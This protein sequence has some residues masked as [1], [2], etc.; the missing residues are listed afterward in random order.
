MEISK[1]VLGII[2]IFFSAIRTINGNTGLAGLNVD[3]VPE[4][5]F[6]EPIENI[7]VP[8]GRE[9]I[10][11]CSVQNLG[12]YKVGW[13]RVSDQTVLALQGRVVTHNA[14]YSV[15]HEDMRTWKLKIRQ[16]RESDRGCYMCQINASPMKKQLGCIDVYVPPDINDEESS[17]DVTARE[18]EDA[19]LFCSAN[20]H[21]TP[22]ITWRREDGAPLLIRRNETI[23]RVDSYYG[24]L[25]NLS[26]VERR[27]MGAYLCIAAN[28]VPPAV[29][30]RVFLNIH[31]APQIVT[32]R[33]LFG[34]LAES[35]VVL[36]CMVEASP[37][38]VNYWI[39]G[40]V[41]KR[42]SYETFT[43][44]EMLLDGKKHH[45]SEE[46]LSPYEFRLKLVVHNFSRSDLGIYTC[47]STNSLGRANGTIRIYEIKIPTT[48]TTST[49]TTTTPKPTTPRTTTT[50]TTAIPTPPPE[51]FTETTTPD[52][53]T[54]FPV[55]EAPYG[56][57]AE[58]NQPLHDIMYSRDSDSSGT[59]TPMWVV[60]CIV[61]AVMLQALLIAIR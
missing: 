39:K 15:I 44:P 11:S 29:S 16:L 41:P 23:A 10:L 50:S 14:R 5:D 60:H 4:P 1:S 61:A 7:T 25:L 32:P 59:S 20:G 27:Q 9:A 30:K 48:T 22:R 21:P 24:S 8:V 12:G 45:I 54:F 57:H 49:T 38:S 2:W 28:D 13:M 26:S 51:T 46:K 36:E 31:F 17:S 52:Y 56:G 47:I 58:A 6:T 40:S 3:Q 33:S 18:G 35:D 55:H 34:G 42:N 19:T 37:I 43:R 53:P